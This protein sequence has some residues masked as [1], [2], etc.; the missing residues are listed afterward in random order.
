MRLIALC[1]LASSIVS[2]SAFPSRAEFLLNCRLMDRHDRL[3]E[4]YCLGDQDSFL[5]VAKCSEHGLCVIKKQ[6][7]KGVYYSEK[8]ASGRPVAEL[9]GTAQVLGAQTG[10][11]AVN[12][13][14]SAADAVRNLADNS[15]RSLAGQ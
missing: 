7:F 3:Y 4:H 6:N 5:V 13:A 14:L 15:A 2:L 1:V 10:L 11:S 8:N 9:G 12:S